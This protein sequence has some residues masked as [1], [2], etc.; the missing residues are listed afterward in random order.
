MGDAGITT[1]A[2]VASAPTHQWATSITTWPGRLADIA[3]CALLGGE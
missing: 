1:E 3:T 2:S